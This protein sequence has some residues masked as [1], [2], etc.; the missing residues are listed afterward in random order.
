M[1]SQ[2]LSHY[3]EMQ[4]DKAVNRL[5][6][7]AGRKKMKLEKLRMENMLTQ[8]SSTKTAPSIN[9]YSRHLVSMREGRVPIHKRAN[10]IVAQKEKRR[11]IIDQMVKEKEEQEQAE[12]TFK[13]KINKESKRL[14]S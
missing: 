1:R 12:L 4:L 2:A 9:S 13:P 10:Q 5:F 14:A 7:D 6:E 8:L 3:S 11:Q